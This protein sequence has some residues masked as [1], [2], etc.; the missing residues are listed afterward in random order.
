M[1]KRDGQ[2]HDGRTHER[3]RQGGI[4]SNHIRF[5]VLLVTGVS[6]CSTW[7]ASNTSTY[8]AEMRSRDQRDEIEWTAQRDLVVVN[9]GLQTV[10]DGDHL[11]GI[12]WITVVVQTNNHSIPF[13]PTCHLQPAPPW[14]SCTSPPH[15]AVCK[16]CPKRSLDGAIGFR[17]DVT[18]SLG[19]H[20]SVLLQYALTHVTTHTR[21][22]TLPPHLIQH[23]HGAAA[24]HRA[25]QTQQLALPQRKVC[26][27]RRVSWA[28][29]DGKLRS[30]THLLAH[31]RVQPLGQPP[32]EVLQ[33]G[34]SQC[35]RG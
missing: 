5:G 12:L 33:L 23:Q 17:I 14:P 4:I 32:H 28:S 2:Q 1:T 20:T 18:G 29:V 25:S 34:R 31:G 19:T 11:H 6:N 21:L 7:P 35:L 24:Q 9:D 22:H 13:S 26:S 15:R 16:S 8:D 30:F 10:R 3:R 27:L